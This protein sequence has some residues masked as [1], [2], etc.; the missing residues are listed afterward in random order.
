M[1]PK[2]SIAIPTYINNELQLSYLRYS[3]DKILEQ[4]F[5][6]F[7]VVISD[8]SLN[9]FVENL[10]N[11]YSD[12]F[13]II[14]FK[15]LDKVGMSQNSNSSMKLCKGDYI[16][17]LH[18]DDFLFSNKSLELI[19]NSLDNSDNYWLVNGFNH[20]HDAVS[21]FD[22]RVPKYTKYSLIGNNLLGCPS[23]VSIR[24]I[25]VP[26]Y[27]PNLHMSMDVEWYHRIRMSHGMPIIIDDVLTTSR[28][29]NNS[30]TS[31]INLDFVIE[32]EEGSWENVQS[33]INYLN[34]KYKD[35]FETWEYP[36]D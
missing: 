29:H 16:K 2:I 24:N 15:N 7:E 33:E 12:Y 1:N 20:T 19:V 26:D 34:E 17:I 27:D 30:T 25:D 18:Y 32:T 5:K 4:T 31:K 9:T 36:N 23:N 35:F 8:N 14:Y 11:E 28:I 3:F 13:S 21:F 22:P 6:N 10:C